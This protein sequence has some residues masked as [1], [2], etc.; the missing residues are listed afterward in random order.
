MTNST[1]VVIAVILIALIGAGF[2]FA[3]YQKK[4]IKIKDLEKQISE[5]RTELNKSQEIVKQIPELMSKRDEVRVKLQTIVNE[6][7]GLEDSLD[8]IPNYMSQMEK[9]IYSVR[10]ETGDESFDVSNLSWT[11]EET[12]VQTKGSDLSPL[13]A[14][15]TRT[16]SMNMKGKYSTLLYFLNQLGALKM[17]RLVTINGISLSPGETKGGVNPILSITLPIKAYLRKAGGPQ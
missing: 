11:N 1:K 9:M 6:R 13:A 8:F 10:S 4:I 3:D 15:P 5:K 12:P 17:K 7:V 14:F 16:Y 2:Y